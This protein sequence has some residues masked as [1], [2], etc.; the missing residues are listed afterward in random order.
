MKPSDHPGRPRR[1]CVIAAISAHK[2]RVRCNDHSLRDSSFRRWFHAKK[3]DFSTVLVRIPKYPNEI[4]YHCRV[5]V[6]K[7][8]GQRSILAQTRQMKGSGSG[9][10]HWAVCYTSY[11]NPINGKGRFQVLYITLLYYMNHRVDIRTEGLMS[12]SLCST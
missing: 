11:V 4:Q 5:I 9:S 3:Y 1:P 7:S 10:E 2:I 8:R 12:R 6:V